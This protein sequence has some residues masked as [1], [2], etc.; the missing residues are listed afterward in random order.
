MSRIPLTSIEQQP[1]PVRQWMAHRG[2]LNVF[3]LLAN[4]PQVFAGWTQMVDELFNSPTFDVR[5]REVV[6]LRV[7]HLQGSRYELS[8]HVGIAR[9]AG[10]SDQQVNAILDNGDLDA[11][12]FSHTERTALAVVTELCTTHRLRDDTFAAAQA[13]FG[14]EALTELLMII[15]CYY[16]LALVLNAVDLDVDAT[17]RFQ[18]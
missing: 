13:V 14:D 11:A 9:N 7:A 12:N 10:M 2:N 4:A 8:Q 1:E 6:I 15:S 18:P 3:R 5:M 17:A 16:G